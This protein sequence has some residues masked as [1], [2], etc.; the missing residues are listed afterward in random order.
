MSKK[1]RQTHEDHQFCRDKGFKRDY[2]SY[3]GD[4]IKGKR[5]VVFTRKDN[6][7]THYVRRHRGKWAAMVRETSISKQFDSPWYEDP[8][9]AF[10][11]AELCNWGQP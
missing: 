11:Y 6:D 5:G 1:N 10:V 7:R 3:M 9:A 8:A 2:T 4:R